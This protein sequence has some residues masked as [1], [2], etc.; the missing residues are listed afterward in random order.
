MRCDQCDKPAAVHFTDASSPDR[1]TTHLCQDHARQALA[2]Q[3]K[4]MAG[5]AEPLVPVDVYVTQ[6]QI[7]RGEEVEVALPDG[8]TRR[9]KIPQRIST[10]L[11]IRHM[12]PQ[13]A[14][15]KFV[16]HIV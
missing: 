12:T 16:I 1:P 7:D 6:E 4:A 10:G 3:P 5:M 8:G 13:R 9:L 11:S 2:G 14:G 15:Y